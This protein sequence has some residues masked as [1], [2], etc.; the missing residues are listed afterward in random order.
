M[1]KI[2]NRYR[3]NGLIILFIEVE[4]TRVKE[5]SVIVDGHLEHQGN[6]LQEARTALWKLYGKESDKEKAKI[7]KRR[8]E[9]RRKSKEWVMLEG[10]NDL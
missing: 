9:R 10:E 3:V 4:F 6:D 2:W 5:Y 8:R 7:N 1:L